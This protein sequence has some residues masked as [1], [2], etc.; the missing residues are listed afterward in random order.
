M[1]CAGPAEDLL[2]LLGELSG[3]EARVIRLRFGLDDDTPQTLAEIGKCLDLSRE[4]VRQIESR[5]LHKL[6][7]PERRGRVK[8]YLEDLD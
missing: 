3:R 1:E 5:A 8:D 7:L 6:R 4:R 2:G